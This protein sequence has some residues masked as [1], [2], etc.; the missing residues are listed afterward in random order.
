MILILG[1]GLTGLST[2]YHLGDR[3]GGAPPYRVV[4]REAEPGGLARSIDADGFVFDF[5]G[6]LL[7][8]RDE[9]IKALVA[10]LLPDGFEGHARRAFIFSK[11]VLTPY[12]FQANTYGLPVEVIRECVEGFVE[13]LIEAARHNGPAGIASRGGAAGDGA[14]VRPAV[15][16]DPALSF[17]D[18]VLRTFGKGIARHFMIPYN[19][20][21]WRR[22]LRE[23]SSDWVSWS[24]PKPGLGDVLQGALGRGEKA[25]GYNPSFLYPRSDGI[26]AL[27]RAF[28]PHVRPPELG[29]RAVAVDL[30]R[31]EVRFEDGETVRY[32]ALVSTAPLPELIAMARPVPD[33]LREAAARL[34]YVSV[35]NANVGLEGATVPDAHWI[36][37]PEPAF[38]FYRMGIPTNLSRRL[39]PAG[40]VALS[41]E[42]SYRR[43]E[44]PGGGFAEAALAAAEQAGLVRGPYR[45]LT[46]RV[47]HLEYGYVVFDEHRRRHLPALLEFLRKHGVISTGRYGAWE[48]SSME[49]AIRYGR[50]A[51]AAAAGM[52][53]VRQ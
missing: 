23:L 12:P 11:G 31:C 49:D 4:E 40:A 38:P 2:A 27:P 52:E 51:A 41:F 21:L 9:S 33:A 42:T 53:G 8:L 24:I 47:L 44:A 13:T 22:D 28:L 14:R 1:A 17:Y 19:E 26:R 32:S 50:E 15:E 10:R 16:P 35:G 46:S 7:H 25:F 34:D 29:K 3:S 6:H 5:T 18:W 45:R 48:Y 43:R 39:A 20:K 37:F 30:T 36:Y